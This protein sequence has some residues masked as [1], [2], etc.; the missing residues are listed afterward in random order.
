MT[1][2]YKQTW[3]ALVTDPTPYRYVRVVKTNEQVTLV[4]GK[5]RVLV[6]P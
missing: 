2:G 5:F 3:S 6:E 4:F 1:T